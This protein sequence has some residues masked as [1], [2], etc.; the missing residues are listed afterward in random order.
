MAFEDYKA[1]YQG[2]AKKG[3]VAQSSGSA[4]AAMPSAAPVAT[5]DITAQAVA[6]AKP[7]RKAF[8]DTSIPAEGLVDALRQGNLLKG[9]FASDVFDALAEDKQLRADVLKKIA[10]GQVA[11]DEPMYRAIHQAL[12][13]G[14]TRLTY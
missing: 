10:D 1:F 14:K 3:V 9:H 2:M 8:V 7:V 4:L 13:E 11:K 12:V 5:P 6:A